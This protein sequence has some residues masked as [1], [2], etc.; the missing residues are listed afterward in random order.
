MRMFSAFLLKDMFILE[1]EQ[2]KGRFSQLTK[3]TLKTFSAF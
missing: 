3:V 1:N 2:E